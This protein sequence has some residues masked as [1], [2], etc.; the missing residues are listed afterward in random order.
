MDWRLPKLGHLLCRKE[1]TVYS[2]AICT[3]VTDYVFLNCEH[4]LFFLCHHL[5]LNIDNDE[6]TLWSPMAK[7]LY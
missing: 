1:Q 7:Y 4:G 6:I 5:K 3:V 2:L